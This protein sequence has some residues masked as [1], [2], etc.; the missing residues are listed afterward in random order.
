VFCGPL[1]E[2]LYPCELVQAA[3]TGKRKRIKKP[4][5]REKVPA[6]AAGIFAQCGYAPDFAA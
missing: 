2:L 5:K 1:L 3:S 6:A 4:S